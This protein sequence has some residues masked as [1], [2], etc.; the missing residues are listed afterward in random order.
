MSVVFES[1]AGRP[2]KLDMTARRSEELA[3]HLLELAK[4]EPWQLE[5]L[6]ANRERLAAVIA[7]LVVDEHDRPG[8]T[9]PELRGFLLTADG[10]AI[11]ASALCRAMAELSPSTRD[12]LAALFERARTASG[13][14]GFAPLADVEAEAAAGGSPPCTVLYERG[15]G[16]LPDPPGLLPRRGA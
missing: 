7:C 8:T 10:S 6:L 13:A 2:W 4:T 3:V 5:A 16:P 1:D 11:G 15:I 12:T 14:V 9:D